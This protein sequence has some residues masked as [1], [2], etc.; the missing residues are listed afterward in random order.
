MPWIVRRAGDHWFVTFVEPPLPEDAFAIDATA[1]NNVLA[2]GK[3]ADEAATAVYQQWAD[4]QAAALATTFVPEPTDG[5]YTLLVALMIAAAQPGRFDPSAASKLAALVRRVA[6][7][8][9]IRFKTTVTGGAE[10]MMRL[11]DFNIHS[12]GPG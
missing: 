11:V 2:G 4:N 12:P 6:T 7:L 10:A 8:P 9:L 3:D 5:P 1:L